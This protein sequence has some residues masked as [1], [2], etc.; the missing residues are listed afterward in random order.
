MQIQNANFDASSLTEDDE[1]DENEE[2]EG[3]G[4]RTETHVPHP[5][6]SART[7]FLSTDLHV[8]PNSLGTVTHVSSTLLQ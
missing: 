2:G 4:L 5:L 3:E 6:H 1:D 8:V 7:S